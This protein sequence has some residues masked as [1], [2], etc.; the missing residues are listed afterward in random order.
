MQKVLLLKIAALSTFLFLSCEKKEKVGYEKVI[1]SKY[2]GDDYIFHFYDLSNCWM[3]H[4]RQNGTVDSNSTTREQYKVEGDSL[5]FFIPIKGII[6]KDKLILRINGSS[7]DKEY[8]K[9]N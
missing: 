2:K 6:L 4:L 8:I 3:Y 9:I 7:I 1:H 5:I